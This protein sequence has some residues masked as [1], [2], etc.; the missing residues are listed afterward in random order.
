MTLSS[1]LVVASGCQKNHS[2]ITVTEIANILGNFTYQVSLI[3]MLSGLSF[4]FVANNSNF[5][6]HNVMN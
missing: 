5:S 1:F 2:T 4:L 3:L 6:M